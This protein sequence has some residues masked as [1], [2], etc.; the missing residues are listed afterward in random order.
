V[1]GCDRPLEL[2]VAALQ[3]EYPPSTARCWPVT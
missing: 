3:T 1:K 2:F